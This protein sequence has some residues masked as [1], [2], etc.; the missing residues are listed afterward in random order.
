MHGETRTDVLLR[1]AHFCSDLVENKS[2]D[3]FLVLG[4]RFFDS[5]QITDSTALPR[6][7]VD[8]GQIRIKREKIGVIR[9]REKSPEISDKD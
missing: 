3:R 5:L 1:C 6:L 9:C 4:T 8:S 2:A 7:A